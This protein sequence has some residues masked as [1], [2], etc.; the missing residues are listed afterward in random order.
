MTKENDPKVSNS[1]LFSLLP[2]WLATGQLT[3][4]CKPDVNIT[5]SLLKIIPSREA[6]A[7]PEAL[8]TSY[9]QER[10]S[11]VLRFLAR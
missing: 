7:D 3:S 4:R 10:M 8:T 6:V 1:K 11:V 2:A 5:A 9:R